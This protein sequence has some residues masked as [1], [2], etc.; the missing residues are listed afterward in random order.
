MIS[1]MR[2]SECNVVSQCRSTPTS[3]T[4]RRRTFAFGSSYDVTGRSL[5]LLSLVP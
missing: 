5:L 2:E 4:I 1:H 3:P